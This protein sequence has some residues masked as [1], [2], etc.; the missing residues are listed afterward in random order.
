M[1]EVTIAESPENTTEVCNHVVYGY[2]DQRGSL[3]NCIL[4]RKIS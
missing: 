4:L 1:F 3:L 2:V